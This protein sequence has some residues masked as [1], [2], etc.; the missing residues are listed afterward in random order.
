MLYFILD[1]FKIL[2]KGNFINY[3]YHNGLQHNH[4]NMFNFFLTLDVLAN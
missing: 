1:E 3:S 2:F 4:Q